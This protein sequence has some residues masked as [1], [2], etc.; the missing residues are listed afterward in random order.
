MLHVALC[1]E[2]VPVTSRPDI[3]YLNN[4]IGKE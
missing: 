1:S 4:K 3:T 2:G